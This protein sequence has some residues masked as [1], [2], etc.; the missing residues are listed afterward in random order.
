MNVAVIFDNFGPYHLARLRAAAQVC[1]LT[2]IEVAAGSAEYQWEREKNAETLKTEKLKADAGISAFS[3]SGFKSFTLFQ[4]DTSRAIRRDEL[5]RKIDEV[6][7]ASRPQVVFIPGWSSRAAFAALLW[8]VQKNVPAVA[9]SES[10]EWDETR[11]GWK[12]WMKR[13]LMG[14][15]AAALV[16]GKPHKDYMVKLGMPAERIFYG[17]DAVDNRC[18]AGKAA[19]VRSAE[20]E[21]RKKNGLPENYFL[22]SARFIEKKNLPRLLQ[23]YARYRKIASNSELQTPN[24]EPWHLVLL[25]DGALRPALSLQFSAL[26]LRPFVHLPG[27]KQYP[28]LPAYYGLAN[29]FIHASTTEPWGLVVNEAMAS[30]LPVLVSNRCGCAADLVR[31]GVNGFTFDPCNVEEIAQKMFQLSAF[32]PFK[33]SAFA[34]A[35][36]EIIS[37]WGTNRFAD[38]LKQA[39]DCALQTGA[40]KDSLVQKWFLKMLIGMKS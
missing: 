11:A 26:N 13:K 8:C 19:E 1:D 18:F 14:L 6:L 23:A 22:A 16:G 34:D 30:G 5:I 25:G 37:S 3:I 33:L 12:E 10:T 15:C 24:S 40:A 9:M 27:F 28:D 20:C 17:Y 39:A 35:S 7:D 29:A 2:A 21:V 31:E 4:D 32:Q 36:L 38:G